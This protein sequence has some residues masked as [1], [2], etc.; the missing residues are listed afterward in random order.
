[1]H[2]GG[3]LVLYTDNQVKTGL[4]FHQHGYASLALAGNNRVNFPMPR[5]ISLVYPIGALLYINPVGYFRNSGL[6]AR[7]PFMTFFMASYQGFYE[8]AAFPVYPQID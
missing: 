7:M 3:R 2:G 5:L 1:M 4:P 8:I 6:L